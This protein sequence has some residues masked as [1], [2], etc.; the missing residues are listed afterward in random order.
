MEISVKMLPSIR[1]ISRDRAIKNAAMSLFVWG[2]INIVAWFYLGIENRKILSGL[3]NPRLPIYLVIYGGVALGVMML[4]FAFIG[5][6][7][8]S[9]VV[10]L[11]GFS[12]FCVGAWNIGYVFKGGRCSFHSKIII[13]KSK[14][15]HL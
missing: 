12:L 6:L 8:L 3:I 2:A 13:H 10:L 4:L 11:D 15:E 7:R 5:A 1:A 9:L 14:I